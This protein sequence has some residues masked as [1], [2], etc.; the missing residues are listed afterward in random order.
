M[1]PVRIALALAALAF[2]GPALAANETI[3]LASTTSVEASGLLAAILPQFTAKT[4]IAVNVVA[5]GTGKAID[6][7]RRGDAD[8]LLVHDPEAEK[9]SWTKAMAPRAGKS[10]GM[11]SSLSARRPIRPR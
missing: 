3:V 10:H 1:R 9:Q 7:A 2:A 4:G 6:T 8:V 5:Q 11:T